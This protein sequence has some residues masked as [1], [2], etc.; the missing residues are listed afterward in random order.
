MRTARSTL[1]AVAFVAAALPD[2]V[3]TAGP[4]VGAHVA[5]FVGHHHHPIDRPIKLD[6][7]VTCR[8]AIDQGEPPPSAVATLTLVQDGRRGEPV[9]RTAKEFVPEDKGD[10]IYYPFVPPFAPGDA[11]LACKPF[12][13]IGRIADRGHPL[14]QGRAAIAPRCHPARHVHLRLGCRWET[15]TAEAADPTPVLVCVLQTRNLHTKVKGDVGL[16]RIHGA[17]AAPHVDTFADYPDDTYAVEA[18]FPLSAIGCDGATI[19]GRAENGRGQ[20][21]WSGSAAVPACRR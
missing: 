7:P 16:V 10:G 11:F 3:A 9:A 1:A 6:E 21:L 19:D 2:A 17:A 18:R 14:W 5:C 20:E 13:V 4:P 15:P 8:I 12:A